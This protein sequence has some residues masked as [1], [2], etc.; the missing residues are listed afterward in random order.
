[1]NGGDLRAAR[2]ARGWTQSDLAQRLGVSQAYVS[3]LESNRRACPER[4]VRKVVSALRLPASTLPVSSEAEP[5]PAD[6]VARALG[7]LGYSGFAHLRHTR[8]LNPAELLVRTLS[9]GNVE[10]RLVEALPWVLVNYPD[11]D[12]PR[13]SRTTCRIGWALS[14]PWRGKSRRG[15]D[16]RLL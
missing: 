10:A 5:L 4:L 11:V 2:A 16:A 15:P 6:G 12:W 7:T 1:M 8:T 9:S 13:P 14:S 3:L